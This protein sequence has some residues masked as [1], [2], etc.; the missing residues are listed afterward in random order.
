MFWLVSSPDQLFVL[1]PSPPTRSRAGRELKQFA[2]A[3][4]Q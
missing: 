4:S 2:G 1:R 3:S